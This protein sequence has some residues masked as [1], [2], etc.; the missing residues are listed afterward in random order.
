MSRNFE[1]LRQAGEK[2]VIFEKVRRDSP[3]DGHN[4]GFPRSPRSEL[5]QGEAVKLVHRLFVFPNSHGPRVVAFSNVDQ[6]NGSSE[7]CS[8][9]GE[10]LGTQV[11]A[12]YV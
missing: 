2:K 10:A 11:L 9:A 6:G 5:A 3:H 4:G 7:V 12:G 8:R 1:L